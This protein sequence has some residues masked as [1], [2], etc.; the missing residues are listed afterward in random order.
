MEDLI[1]YKY[2]ILKGFVFGIIPLFILGIMIA[3]FN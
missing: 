1:K 3:A 2:Q